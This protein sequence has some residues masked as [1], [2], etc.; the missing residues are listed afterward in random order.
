MKV[1]EEERIHMF[2]T[3]FF[4]MLALAILILTGVIISQKG[5]LDDHSMGQMS[6]LINYLFNPMMM[7]SSAISSLGDID[8]DA[9]FLLFAIVI[10][11]YLA[12]I[13]V[14]HFAAPLFDR[15]PGQKELYQLMLIFSNVGFMGIPVVQ[16]VFGSAYV[17]YVLAFVVGYNVFFYTYGVALMNG[18]FDGKAL[19]SAVN[20]GSICTLI[21][22]LLVILEPPIPGFLATAVEYLG[23]VTSPLAMIA[24]GVTLSKADLKAVFTSKKM[25]LFTLVKMLVIPMLALPLLKA[26]PFSPQVIGVSLV[27]ISMPVANLVLIIGTEKKLDCSNVSGSIIMTTLV[28]MITIPILVALI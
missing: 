24:V 1:Q 25:Y 15:R 28:S 6:V 22:L 27:E 8:K 20:P 12:L 16:G 3:V 7:L 13:L 17:V 23:N 5:L 21:A 4:Q 10:G 18:G 19:K 14:A 2:F 26:L 9:L 11:M